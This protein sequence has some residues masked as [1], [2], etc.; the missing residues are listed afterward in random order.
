MSVFIMN[1]EIMVWELFAV[2]GVLLILAEIFVSGFFVL[3][4]GLAFILSAIPAALAQ[5]WLVILS[6]LALSL[7]FLFWLFKIQLKWG[8]S[9][10]SIASTNV[11][12]MIGKEV[13]VVQEIS[14]SKNGYVK[15]YGDRWAAQSK[16]HKSF[17]V[18]EKVHIIKVDGNKVLVD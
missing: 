2:L 13:E 1:Q 5:S 3:P 16:T 7:I 14:G 15:L 18:G 6:T 11:D 9:S 8:V 4:I 12:A 17:S 10:I